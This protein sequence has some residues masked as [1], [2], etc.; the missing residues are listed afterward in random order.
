[1]TTDALGTL[2][3]LLSE[4]ILIIDGAT[5][6][7]IQGHRLEEADF[8]GERFADHPRPLA[9]NNDLLTLTRPD[10]VSGIHH[11][12]LDA[13]ADIVETNTFSSTAVAQADYGTE[14]LVRE[15]NAEAAR[16]ARAAADESPARTS[17]TPRRARSRSRSCGRPTPSRRAA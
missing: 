6:T 13:G 7:M 3:R 10:V 1:V 8:R 9:G 2:D 11:A 17:R 12:F 14:H 16:L 5:G 15:L 4:R